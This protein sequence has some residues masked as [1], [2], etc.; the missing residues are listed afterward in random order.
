LCIRPQQ[1]ASFRLTAPWKLK[2]QISHTFRQVSAAFKR[3]A[4]GAVCRRPKRSPP[5]GIPPSWP[6]RGA[7][8]SLQHGFKAPE[9]NVRSFEIFL[10]LTRQ[11]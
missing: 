10:I 9:R 6:R 2:R 3:E 4:R 8:Y 7:G 5:H 11:K 1:H